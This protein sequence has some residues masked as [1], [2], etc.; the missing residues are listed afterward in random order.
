MRTENGLYSL[1]PIIY[2]DPLSKPGLSKVASQ[3]KFVNKGNFIKFN[4]YIKNM[5]WIYRLV[6]TQNTTSIDIEILTFP[7]YGVIKFNGLLLFC[8]SNNSLQRMLVIEC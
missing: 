4:Q 6:D 3:S 8:Y 7:L 2:I 1:M 5:I